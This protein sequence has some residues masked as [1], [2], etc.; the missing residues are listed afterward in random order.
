MLANDS[1]DEIKRFFD[2]E[3]VVG[4]SDHLIEN[5]RISVKL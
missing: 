2:H 4:I 3:K 1:V 5:H